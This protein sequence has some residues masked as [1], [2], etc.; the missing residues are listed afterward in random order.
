M[1]FDE[2]LSEDNRNKLNLLHYLDAKKH[3][4]TTTKMLE[5]ILHCSKFKVDKYLGEL[6][7]ELASYTS[8]N[9]SLTVNEAAEV[10]LKNV[11]AF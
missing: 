7:E 6:Q 3:T 4:S 1:N 9:A 2:L 10:K 8:E 11:S 5:G